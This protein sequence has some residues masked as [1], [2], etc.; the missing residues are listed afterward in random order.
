MHTKKKQKWFTQSQKNKDLNLVG[1]RYRQPSAE[2]EQIITRN[3]EILMKSKPW[4]RY[5]FCQGQKKEEINRMREIQFIQILK[6]KIQGNIDIKIDWDQNRGQFLLNRILIK[7]VFYYMFGK[8]F[9]QNLLVEENLIE[10]F[11][12]GINL[13]NKKKWLLSCSYNPKKTSLSNHITELIKSLNL[14]T[15]TYERLI[16]LGDFNAGIEDSS[17]K[18]FCSNFNFTSMINKPT[19][20]KNPDKPTCIDLILTNCPGSF[21]SSCVIE[22]S[23]RFS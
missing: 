22:R 9:L 15:A 16:F 20:Y 6:E 17:I 19:S 5:W 14:L 11:F 4:T 21:Q 12:V 1:T 7:E 23:F 8:I 18:I 2:T 10:G 3:C 13:R